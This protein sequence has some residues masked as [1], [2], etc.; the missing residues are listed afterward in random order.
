MSRAQDGIVKGL[1][2]NI[3]VLVFSKVHTP[4]TA[5]GSYTP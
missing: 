2:L 1:E 5:F 4:E 3:S